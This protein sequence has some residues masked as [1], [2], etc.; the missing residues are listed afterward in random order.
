MIALRKSD[1]IWGSYLKLSSTKINNNYYA[2]LINLYSFILWMPR[3]IPERSFLEHLTSYIVHH[4]AS[5]QRV[6]ISLGM[7]DDSDFSSRLPVT[8]VGSRRLLTGSNTIRHQ[9]QHMTPG[10]KFSHSKNPGAA[11]RN[12]VTT[13]PKI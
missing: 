2:F 13:H 8:K 10:S 6:M 9:G 7:C 4:H 1:I 11:M 3:Y 5:G 12:L